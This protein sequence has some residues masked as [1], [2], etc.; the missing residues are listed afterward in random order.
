M[1]FLESEMQKIVTFMRE[2]GVTHYSNGEVDITIH[3][4]ALDIHSSDDDDGIKVEAS[5]QVTKYRSDYDD[6]M[7]YPDGIDPIADQRE[8]LESQKDKTL[9]G[10]NQ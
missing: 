9:V 6:P 2:N 4:S 3:Q 7:L 8:W 10:L 1:P 5:G